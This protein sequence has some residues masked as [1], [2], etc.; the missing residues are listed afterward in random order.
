[1]LAH[2]PSAEGSR[3]A[4]TVAASATSTESSTWISTSGASASAATSSP[5]ISS[6]SVVSGTRELDGLARLLEPGGVG[7][8]IGV[9]QDPP[10]RRVAGGGQAEQV[11]A[12]AGPHLVTALAPRIGS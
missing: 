8:R 2:S 1:M 10:P 3:R 9:G 12:G 4:T 5:S 11:E 7:V 6:T